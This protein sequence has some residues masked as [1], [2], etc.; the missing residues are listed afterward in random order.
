MT[1]AC[2]ILF[3]APVP[4]AQ[5]PNRP[6]RAPPAPEVSPPGHQP[7]RPRPGPGRR[8]ARPGQHPDPVEPVCALLHPEGAGR[9]RPGPD[10][11]TGEGDRAGVVWEE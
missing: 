2:P 5:G 11:H 1:G 4:P 10:C 9:H 6:A 3:R 8:T 7:P